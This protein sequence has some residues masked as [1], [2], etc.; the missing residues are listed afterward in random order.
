MTCESLAGFCR[1]LSLVELQP[2]CLPRGAK[3]GG[4][5]DTAR[6]DVVATAALDAV[7]EAVPR[8]LAIIPGRDRPKQQLRQQSGAGRPSR[9]RRSGCTA[10]RGPERPGLPRSPTTTQFTRLREWHGVR[11]ERPA[12]HGST[13]DQS[14]RFGQS[15]P[16]QAATRS[17]IG[18]PS[19]ASRFAGCAYSCCRSP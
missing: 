12:R 17:A 19:L 3:A 5:R 11:R 18:V 15:Y 16:P 2:S 1:A 13:G 4:Q 14:Q 9:S 6:A 10:S 7:G 8:D